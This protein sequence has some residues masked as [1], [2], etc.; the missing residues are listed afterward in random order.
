MP[1]KSLKDQLS[2]TPKV[3]K[4]PKKKASKPT[5]E[6][7]VEEK[8]KVNRD[9]I[10]TVMNITSGL[11]HYQS[12]KTG[13]EWNFHE[14]G[15][16]DEIEVSE[17]VTM[18]NAHPRYL[19]EPWLIVLDED[20]VDFLGMSKEYEGVLT[21]DELD[22]F[23]QLPGSKIK[24]L[25]PSMPRGMKEAVA[26]QARIRIEQETLTNLNVIKAIEEVLKIEL[27]S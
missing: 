11:V 13:S 22:R 5:K 24:E 16:T 15:A 26:D 4:E 17:L 21:P 9:D 10:V 3:E 19:K 18:K 2:Q 27:M 14:F 7:I 1:K 25:L 8:R 12:K 23:Y 20:V 6:E